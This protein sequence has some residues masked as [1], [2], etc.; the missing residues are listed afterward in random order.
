MILIY[1]FILSTVTVNSTFLPYKE[2]CDIYS[3]VN[4]PQ[5]T[6]A[7]ELHF[8]CL[9]IKAEVSLGSHYI[10]YSESGN[11]VERFNFTTI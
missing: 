6:G 7:I 4:L 3:G 11:K 10:A 5:D 2:V 9:D 8:G 1:L